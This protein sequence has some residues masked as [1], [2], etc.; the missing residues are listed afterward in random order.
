MKLTSFDADKRAFK[1]GVTCIQS[2]K[3]ISISD[4]GAGHETTGVDKYITIIELDN[5]FKVQKKPNK[6]DAQALMHWKENIIAMKAKTESGVGSIIQIFNLGKKEK[7]KNMEFNEQVVFWAWISLEKLAIVTTTS[8]YH[9][10]ITKKE[11][12]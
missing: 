4:T 6:A 9:A 8:V 12:P 2:E 3:Y 7:L 11:E 5:N 10:D 1:F